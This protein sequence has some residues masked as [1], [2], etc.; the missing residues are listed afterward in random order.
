MSELEQE[1]KL[2]ISLCDSDRM[3]GLTWEEVLNCEVGRKQLA[4]DLITNV[5]PKTIH[6]KSCV[7]SAVVH[8]VWLPI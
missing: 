5:C 2:A 6:F 8:L 7:L 4:T 3:V 1:E